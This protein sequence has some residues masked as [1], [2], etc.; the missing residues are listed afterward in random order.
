MAGKWAN[1]QMIVNDENVVTLVWTGGKKV[2]FVGDLYS[3]VA[4]D[5]LGNDGW[6]FVGAI[7]LGEGREK[8]FFK[9]QI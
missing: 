9:K 7:A 6:E 5:V 3:A 2:P 1:L 4:A 8:H